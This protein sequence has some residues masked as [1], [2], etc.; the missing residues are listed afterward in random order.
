MSTHALL[1]GPSN[2]IYV[3][4]A[5]MPQSTCKVHDAADQP[6]LLNVSDDHKLRIN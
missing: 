6:S 1:L 4:A 3:A 2:H 5:A